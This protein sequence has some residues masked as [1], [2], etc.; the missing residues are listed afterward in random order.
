MDEE[1]IALLMKNLE[2]TREEAIQVMEDDKKI[3]KGEKLFELTPEQKK[4]AKQQIMIKNKAH[5][6]PTVREKK[7]DNDKAEII[8]IL[9]NA[10]TEN[11]MDNF[12]ITNAERE[13]TFQANG[14]KLKIV[15][16]A[17]RS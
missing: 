7:V 9:V 5:K 11:G 8:Q 4:F 2:L 1:K 14:R 17:P 3:D 13:F 15:L 6:K 12:E 16:S 10:L